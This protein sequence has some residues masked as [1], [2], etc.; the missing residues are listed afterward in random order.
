MD[1][2]M[3]TFLASYVETSIDYRCDDAEK[4]AQL[5]R[6]LCIDAWLTPKNAGH[7]LF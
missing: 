7:C 2:K 5:G 3:E 4:I 1:M 6:H